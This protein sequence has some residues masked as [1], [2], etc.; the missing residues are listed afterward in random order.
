MG[1]IKLKGYLFIEPIY[2][3]HSFKISGIHGLKLNR[4]LVNI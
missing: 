3:S 1:K 2:S 4:W